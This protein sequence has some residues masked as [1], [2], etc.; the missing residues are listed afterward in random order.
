MGYIP[1]P[2]RNLGYRGQRSPRRP[3]KDCQGPSESTRVCFGL[4][5]S[6]PAISL[7]SFGVR[8]SVGTLIK[9]RR[10]FNPQDDTIPIPAPPN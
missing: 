10:V 2:R 6:L 7:G 8:D 9:T 4:M 3:M 1:I 5:G